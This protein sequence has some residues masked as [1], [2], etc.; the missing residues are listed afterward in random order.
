V[1]D[2]QADRYVTSSLQ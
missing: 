1:T 2:R